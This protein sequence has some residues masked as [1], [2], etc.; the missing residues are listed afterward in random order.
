MPPASAQRTTRSSRKA[1]AA[2][3]PRRAPPTWC[4]GCSTGAEIRLR[5]VPTTVGVPVWFVV[6]KTDLLDTQAIGNVE[7]S[8]TE[9]TRLPYF[10]VSATTGAGLGAM[11]DRIATFA[12]QFFWGEPAL[13]TR[14]RH[15]MQMSHAVLALEAAVAL[16]ETGGTDGRE[17]LVAEHIRMATRALEQLTGR[18]DVEDILDVIFRDFCIGK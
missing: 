18:I 15:Q 9:P 7:V 2:R 3:R 13:A 6:N 10:A 5:D 1:C 4:C 8:F 14:Q 12:G 16:A 17:E 11:I